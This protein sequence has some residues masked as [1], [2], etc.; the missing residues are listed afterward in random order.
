MVNGLKV[1]HE[2]DHTWTPEE[3]EAGRITPAGEPTNSAGISDTAECSQGVWSER[4]DRT[5]DVSA[6]L[7]M[8][9]KN[10]CYFIEVQTGMT[11]TAARDLLKRRAEISRTKRERTTLIISM[12]AAGTAVVAV[13][14]SLFNRG[15]A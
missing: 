3:R 2:A 10:Q 12:I 11:Y 4:V 13:M 6:E 14:V 8:D 7:D 1:V 9:R 5:M 15:V